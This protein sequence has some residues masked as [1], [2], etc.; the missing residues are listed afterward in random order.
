MKE[1]RMIFHIP[2][3]IDKEQKSG[4]QI[5]PMKLLQAFRNIGYTVDAVMGTVRERKKQIKEI[6][7]NIKQGIQY[8]FLY[9]ES[10]TMPT[11][12]T[13]SHHLPIAPFLDFSFFSYCKK[14]SIK[15]GL[16]Y[17]D[18][19]WNFNE[20]YDKSS[21]LKRIAFLFYK[22]DLL[23]Y[24]KILDVF[25]LPSIEMYKYI[26]IELDGKV[27]A[28]PPAVDT[29][30]LTVNTQRCFSENISFIYVGGIGKVYDLSL[31]FDTV[32]DF[33]NFKINI[34]TRKNE[35]D[36]CYYKYSKYE[37]K[38]EINHVSGDGL[39]SIYKKSDIAVYFLKP[40]RLWDF[41]IGIKLFEYMAYRKPIIAVKGTAVG[42][43]VESN[44]IGWVINYTKEDLEKLLRYLTNNRDEI[45]KKI[46]NI[47]KIILN[48]TWEARAR[49]VEKDL[50]G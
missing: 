24:N 41:A 34:C 14:N 25:Y 28:L 35:W 30:V 46:E 16:F 6:K 12:L 18:I 3:S 1:K 40:D 39:S 45:N 7:K 27:L 8:D 44:D 37:K 20:Y 47:E 4:S 15:I 10:S 29:K 13:E 42:N 50:K 33:Q 43:F 11:A 23:H 9:S 17:R 5:R 19:Y 26:P 49:Q 32:L 21:L 2:N 38:Y 48:H 31:F 36:S 22:F